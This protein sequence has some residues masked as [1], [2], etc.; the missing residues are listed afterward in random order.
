MLHQVFLN[1]MAIPEDA[2]Q[3]ILP[4][5]EGGAFGSALDL[6]DEAQICSCENVSKGQI[7]GAIKDGSCED[8]AGVISSTKASTSCGGCKPMVTDLVNGIKKID[9][10]KDVVSKIDQIDK[11]KAPD[12]QK[13]TDPVS[14]FAGAGA[15]ISFGKDQYRLFEY[16][17]DG[18]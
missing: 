1:G 12:M 15:N 4:A 7:C 8:L 6:P 5:T 14:K 10:R 3:L 11:M 13:Q 17:V 9:F 2:A 18:S 16:H